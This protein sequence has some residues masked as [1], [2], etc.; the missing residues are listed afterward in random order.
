VRVDPPCDRDRGETFGVLADTVQVMGARNQRPEDAA[1]FEQLY[2]EHAPRV[3]AYAAR[4]LPRDVVA[5]VVAETFSVAWR[6]LDLVPVEPG[7]W[8]LA[9]ARR[10]SANQRRS[11]RRRAALAERAAAHALVFF[12]VE[13][14]PAVLEALATL[15]ER[16][17]E[18]LLLAAWDGLS[19][20]EA[21]AVLGCSATAYRLRLYRAR[22]K[23]AARLT[24]NPADTSEQCHPALRVEEHL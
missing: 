17:R 21:A 9:V 7:P 4:R 1:R 24:P 8:L 16:D 19:A 14:P 13:D 6:R 2:R 20:A 5:D 10:V 18:A 22:R 12:E 3:I 23:L 15:S 11:L